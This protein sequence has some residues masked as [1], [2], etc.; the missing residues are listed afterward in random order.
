[1]LS[2]FSNTYFP[3]SDSESDSEETTEIWKCKE[4]CRA[5]LEVSPDNQLV[6][7][8]GR[9]KC[10]ET[11]MKIIQDLGRLDDFIFHRDKGELK[12]KA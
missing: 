1:M 5:E 11:R 10:A 9:H 3:G 7:H 6:A 2:S 8:R 12:G 4:G